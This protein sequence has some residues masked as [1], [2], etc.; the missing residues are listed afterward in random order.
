MDEMAM[1]GVGPPLLANGNKT[2]FTL[3]RL[4][5]N[6]EGELSELK[7]FEASKITPKAFAEVRGLA[8][9]VFLR[10]KVVPLLETLSPREDPDAPLFASTPPLPFVPPVPG[11][12]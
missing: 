2:G 12:V 3:R 10:T 7:L 5:G 4:A 9:S 1:V 6:E 8:N 11:C